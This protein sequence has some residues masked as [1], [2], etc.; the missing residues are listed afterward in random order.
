MEK[1]ILHRKYSEQQTTGVLLVVDGDRL[2]FSCNTI[3]PPW[4][5]NLKNESCIYESEFICK[6]I[7]S[8][9]YGNCI[10]VT[11]VK[12]RTHIL[13]H[14]GNYVS[15][16]DGCIIVGDSFKDINN[17]NLKDVINSQITFNKLMDIL[18]NSF[19]LS[20]CSDVL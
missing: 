3:E 10:E 16:T 2:L 1:L 7:I 13:I 15:N 4:K 9:T 19:K 6:K 12:G 20:I 17:D 14:W 8:P 18:P 11:E 5:F